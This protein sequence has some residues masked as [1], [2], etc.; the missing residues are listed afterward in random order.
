MLSFNLAG[1][2]SLIYNLICLLPRISIIIDGVKKKKSNQK[3]YKISSQIYLHPIMFSVLFLLVNATLLWVLLT[4]LTLSCVASWNWVRRNCH[5]H[6]SWIC[7]PKVCSADTTRG[8]EGWPKSE[9]ASIHL[10]FKYESIHLTFVSL[11]F[12]VCYQY[13]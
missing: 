13:N 8:G 5:L 3:T 4:R 6:I 7:N 10:T 1:L 12:F 9:S 11:A 2:C